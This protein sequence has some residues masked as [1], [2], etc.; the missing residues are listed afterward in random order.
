MP[1]AA[2]A[3]SSALGLQF[4]RSR[5]R[6]AECQVDGGTV[7]AGSSVPISERKQTIERVRKR[8]FGTWT[9][10]GEK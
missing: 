4:V 6:L 9:L 10:L 1:R 3:P 5:G 8:E 2:I 7:K